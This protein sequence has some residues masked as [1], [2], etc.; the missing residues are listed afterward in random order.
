M[1]VARWKQVPHEEFNCLSNKHEDFS[2]AYYSWGIL[3]GPAV[4]NLPAIQETRVQS[5]GQEDPL[6]KE[7]ATCSSI[8]AWKVPL[9]EDPGGLQ[10]MGWQELGVEAVRTLAEKMGRGSTL[11]RE[12]L[13]QHGRGWGHGFEWITARETQ[14]MP[15]KYRKF[16]A[17]EWAPFQGH[18][19]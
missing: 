10:S 8:L 6:E 1:V 13:E 9:R 2:I 12:A 3:G 16:P 14:T 19:R 7:M 5:L 18:V 17:Y 15:E 4:K 11:M